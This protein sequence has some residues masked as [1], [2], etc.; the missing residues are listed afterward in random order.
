MKGSQ[1]EKDISSKELVKE[2][3]YVIQRIGYLATYPNFIIPI[4]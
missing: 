3:K 2:K 4:K 1:Q